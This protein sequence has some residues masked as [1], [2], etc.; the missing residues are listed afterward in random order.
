LK[1]AT[2]GR[3]WT[4]FEPLSPE[5]S[6]PFYLHSAKCSLPYFQRHYSYDRRRKINKT[7]AL[8]FWWC[9]G[10][11]SALIIHIPTSKWG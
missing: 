2:Q 10:T 6:L 5:T 11:I 4:K 8:R 9:A 7:Y 1:L 3:N